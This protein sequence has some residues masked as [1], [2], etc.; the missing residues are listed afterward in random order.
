MELDPRYQ[1]ARDTA[2]ADHE[3]RDGWHAVNLELEQGTGHSRHSLLMALQGQLAGELHLD[4]AHLDAHADLTV[5]TARVT[6]IGLQKLEDLVLRP[7]SE[8]VRI[9]RRFEYAQLLKPP[10]LRPIPAHR[11]PDGIHTEGTAGGAAPARNGPPKAVRTVLA[12]IDYGCPFMHPLL[13]TQT[14]AGTSTRVRALWDQQPAAAADTRTQPKGFDYGAEFSREQLN[15]VILATGGDE[16]LAYEALGCQALRLRRSH[17]A[18]ALG[19][20]LDDGLRPRG[21]VRCEPA[22]DVLFVQLPQG[23]LGAPNRAVLSRHVVD[24]LVWIESQR[25][26]DERVILSLSEGSSQGPNDGS[27]I[28]EQA[29]EW[30]T[31]RGVSGKGGLDPDGLH[32]N[33]IYVAAGNGH[34]ERLHA[35]A[36]LSPSAP[37]SF[38]WRVPPASELPASVEIWVP[39]AA[40]D[41]AADVQVELFTPDG[42]LAAKAV[43]NQ[44]VQWPGASAAVASLAWTSWRGHGCTLCVIRL[45]PTAD[46]SGGVCAPFGDWT[47]RLCTQS[48][49]T[50]AVHLFIGRIV[51]A[52]GFPM[53]TAQSTFVDNGRRGVVG[54]TGEGTLQGLATAKGV[55]RVGGVTRIQQRWR[56]AS[57]SSR[58]PSRDLS[59]DGP[60]LSVQVDDDEVLKGRR[61]IGNLSGVSLRMTGTSVAAP[62]AARLDKDTA[63]PPG[64]GP[65][66]S[67]QP[68][69]GASGDKEMGK[70]LE[71]G[72]EP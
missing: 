51:R 7:A 61:S 3:V 1:I 19:M 20:L 45:A 65:Y 26:H 12:V 47:I 15:S 29:L 59:I 4:P 10:R 49:P 69:S 34:E 54:A 68:P 2:F 58:G 6:A 55:I 14:D 70:I 46:T 39:D 37:K 18:H 64:P 22:A 72:S 23:L 56:P 48:G 50:S 67:R 44:T 31:R 36:A 40:Q 66:D 13:C 71:D 17:G 33:R 21:S 42:R 28:V 43:A 35:Q 27:S 16:G 11:L 41:S 62:L 8:S 52:L 63:R 60:D 25:Q 57:F 32:L 9:L 53:R 30:F 38:L 24:A 5:A